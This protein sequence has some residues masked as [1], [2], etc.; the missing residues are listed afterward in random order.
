MSE[1]LIEVS[2]LSKLFRAKGRTVQALHDVSFSVAAGEAFGF[3][4]PNGAGKSTTIKILLDIV[5]DYEGDV[6]LGGRPA[7]EA[8]SRIGVGYVPESPALYEVLTPLDL[9]MMAVAM[10]RVRHDS[11]K[12]LC[13]EWLE[14]FS[15]ADAAMRRI[16]ELSK[17]TVQRV[18]LAHA[19]VVM[20]RIL[21]LDE[22]LSGLDPIGRRDVVDVLANYRRDGGTIFFT[23][24]VLHDVERVADRFALIHRG[25]LR[26]VR[27]PSELLGESQMVT[28]RT[29]GQ[30]VV[31]GMRADFDGRWVTEIASEGLWQLLERLR[32]AGH[33]VIEIRPMLSLEA[34]FMR[35]VQDDIRADVSAVAI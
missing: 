4:G 15:V 22:P 32:A 34:A 31:E 30:A 6:L 16:R 11:P 12:R 13:M 9:L 17:G 33:V 29:V 19:M 18:A 26:T 23:S 14:R 2:G 3:I 10:H 8:G 25:R 20:P 7:R 21:I 28:V 24:H 35:F 1:S 5:S 27:S